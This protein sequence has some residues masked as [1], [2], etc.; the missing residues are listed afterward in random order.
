MKALS[1]IILLSLG[2]ASQLPA[3]EYFMSLQGAGNQSGE[4]WENAFPFS[5]ADPVINTTMAPGDTLFLEGNNYGSATLKIRASGNEEARM[6]LV[7]VDRGVEGFPRPA[8]MGKSRSL[9]AGA[10]IVLQQGASFWTL[11][12]LQSHRR[13]WGLK[14]VGQNRRLIID[15]VYTH[16]TV[17]G[18]GFYDCDELLVINCKAERYT[19]YGFHL[20]HSCDKVIIRRC[21]AD[22]SGTGDEP[23][24][25]WWRQA[26]PV[27][28]YFHTDRGKDNPY[29][30]QI[31]VEDCVTRNNRE[32]TPQKGDFEQGDGFMAEFRNRD[33][34]FRRC[35]SYDNQQGAYDM[36]GEEQVFEDCYALRSGNG[37]KIWNNATMTNCIA[38]GTRGN[39]VMLIGKKENPNHIL[40]AEHCTFHVGTQGTGAAVWIERGK[41]GITQATLKNCLVTRAKSKKEYRKSSIMGGYSG[42]GGNVDLLKDSPD[43]SP[44]FDKTANLENPPQYTR[45]V[46]PWRP[47]AEPQTASAFD[48]QTFGKTKGYHSTRNPSPLPLWAAIIAK[49][50]RERLPLK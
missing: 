5:E 41:R 18:F 11:K 32:Q 50:D 27:G 44:R 19:R 23:D 49:A 14:T 36:K 9:N 35:L 6:Q 30:T 7:G 21:Y 48:S 4:N 33:L 31:L 15:S 25:G 16:N 8:F 22:C 34:T 12:N 43:V 40:N 28:F 29:N 47:W 20:A 10:N 17:N 39:T 46:E 2:T 24:P 37:F 1:I 3:A 38:A 42:A 45:F 13:G 26:N